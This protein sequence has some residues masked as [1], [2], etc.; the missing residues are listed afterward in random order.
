MD[1]AEYKQLKDQIE[2][3][4][5]RKMEALELVWKMSQSKGD[6]SLKGDI[7]HAGRSKSDSIRSVIKGL[8]GGFSARDVEQGLKDHG[9]K[10]FSR[11][12]ITNTLHRLCRR[13]ELE[14]VRKGQGRIAGT[15]RK[16]LEPERINLEA[17]E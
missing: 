15:Y 14:S 12:H 13:G 5:L 11:I 8:E 10:G 4:R 2:Q 16:K 17:G 1:Y 6:S 9:I 7:T 3:E